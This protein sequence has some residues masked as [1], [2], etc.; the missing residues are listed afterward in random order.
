[1]VCFLIANQ[2]LSANGHW[3]KVSSAAIISLRGIMT[4]F[5]H[6]F[7]T[8]TRSSG[9]FE[10]RKVAVGNDWLGFWSNSP[11]STTDQRALSNGV[12][13]PLLLQREHW[14]WPLVGNDKA[15]VQRGKV[16]FGGVR[17]KCSEHGRGWS[18]GVHECLPI[19][20]QEGDTQMV[21]VMRCT[22]TSNKNPGVTSHKQRPYE[23]AVRSKGFAGTHVGDAILVHRKKPR[24]FN[25]VFIVK[26]CF[27]SDA[28]DGYLSDLQS[29]V[30]NNDLKSVSAKAV[31]DAI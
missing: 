20:D 4:Q 3:A 16:F 9:D 12:D 26:D 29:A 15:N 23:V 10:P 6:P 22:A 27:V 21:R 8:S 18:I 24:K 14:P 13:G 30:S 28:L 2:S 11:C 25:R 31:G 5:K 19:L 17:V 7:F 1:M